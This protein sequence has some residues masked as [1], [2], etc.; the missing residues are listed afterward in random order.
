MI[1]PMDLAERGTGCADVPD[2]PPQGLVSVYGRASAR[3][4]LARVRFVPEW[5]LPLAGSGVEYP[6]QHLVLIAQ[7][8]GE[9]IP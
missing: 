2:R 6:G 3:L 1:L 8:R 4:R 5:R 9:G 7:R